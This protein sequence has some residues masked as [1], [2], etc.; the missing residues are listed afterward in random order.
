MNLSERLSDAISV[1]IKQYLPDRTKR[2]ILLASLSGYICNKTILD[3][4][5]IHK[6]NEVM[7]LSA[8]DSALV[9]PI[10][11]S[12]MIWQKRIGDI[13]IHP[14]AQ[15]SSEKCLATQLADHIPQCLRYSTYQ[16]MLDDIKKLLENK[17]VLV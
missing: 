3:R 15:V 9:V 14:P 4:Q 1:K 11:Y 13:F 17:P 8:S 10:Q 16:E 5:A 2:L 6:L 12:K 7:A